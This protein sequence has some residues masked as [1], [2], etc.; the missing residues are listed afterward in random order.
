M[1]S[2]QEGSNIVMKPTLLTWSP[3]LALEE[4]KK[5]DISFGHYV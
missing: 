5:L 2:E 1:L 3:L 4:P